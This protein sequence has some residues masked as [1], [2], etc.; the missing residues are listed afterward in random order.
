MLPHPEGGPASPGIG[1]YGLTLTLPE[2]VNAERRRVLAALGAKLVLTPMK[3]G[4]RGAIARA[5]EIA[6]SDPARA[7]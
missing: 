2:T 6:A 3:A 1:G 5:E 4:V 7:R